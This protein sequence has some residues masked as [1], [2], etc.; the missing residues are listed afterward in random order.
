MSTEAPRHDPSDLTESQRALLERFLP[1]PKSG[2]GKPGRPGAD[3]G[4]VLN[5]LLYVVKTGC[6][7]R[8][9]PREFGP[10]QTV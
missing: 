6:Q 7:W 5:A 10:W 9:M 2:P 4:R 1:E 8:Q 3:R